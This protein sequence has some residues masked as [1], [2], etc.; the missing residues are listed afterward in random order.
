[1]GRRFQIIGVLDKVGSSFGGQGVDRTIIVPVEMAGRL[2]AGRALRYSITT[3]L[4]NPLEL[5]FAMGEATSLMR[6]IRQDRLGKDQSFDLE[7]SESL[8]DSMN[9]VTGYLKIG[10]FTIGFITLLGAS[11]GL[12]NIMMVSVTERTKEIGVRK[13]LGATPKRIRQQFLIEAI[14]ICLLGGLVGVLL[15]I[16]FGNLISSIISSGSFFIPW[17]WIFFGLTVCVIVGLISGYYPAFKASKLDPI[18]SLR[19]E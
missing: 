2:A 3:T 8:A 17:F 6:S 4:N 13:A 5:E 16:S 1:L 14:V 15:G 12:M 7:R 11:I 18:E 9:E 19:F 10:G